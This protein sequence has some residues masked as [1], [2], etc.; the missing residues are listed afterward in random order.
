MQRAH[1]PLHTPIQWREGAPHCERCDCGQENVCRVCANTW[2]A[3]V[4]LGSN[5]SLV[6]IRLGQQPEE[7]RPLRLPLEC[8]VA[9]STLWV[10]N[11]R[12][13]GLDLWFCPDVR[14]SHIQ[15]QCFTKAQ[16]KAKQSY[17]AKRK[18]RWPTLVKYLFNK[19]NLAFVLDEQGNNITISND[20]V[21]IEK[22][23]PAECS[24]SET[25]FIEPVAVKMY[26][27]LVSCEFQAQV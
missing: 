21:N 3:A 13:H 4:L 20:R 19:W 14:V 11:N 5:R 1:E 16:Q 7:Q 8:A 12:A 24:A 17:Y 2:C 15:E 18:E 26:N 22:Q 27:S 25:N 9:K 23:D 10:D 6:G